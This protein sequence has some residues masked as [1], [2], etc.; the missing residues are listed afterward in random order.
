MLIYNVTINIDEQVHRPWLDW[1]RDRHIPDMLA[2]GKFTH[3]KLARVLVEGD[4]GGITYSVQYTVQDRKTL[5]AYYREDAQRLRGEAHGHFPNQFV[6][7]RTEL[8]VI[9]QQIP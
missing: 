4:Q 7:F 2:T 9:S 6:S 5:E 3:A 8:E 1:M